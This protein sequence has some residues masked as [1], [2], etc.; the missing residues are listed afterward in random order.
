[1]D[2][3]DIREDLSINFD[4]YYSIQGVVTDFQDGS[5]KIGLKGSDWS[6]KTIVVQ[7][8]TGTMSNHT[9]LLTGAAER[10][11]DSDYQY[12]LILWNTTATSI[13][14]DDFV[15]VDTNYAT[16]SLSGVTISNDLSDAG[17]ESEDSALNSGNDDIEIAGG[18]N[19]TVTR[20]NANKL[21]ISSTDTDT[22]TTYLLK[23]QQTDGNN[24]NPNLFL[25]ASGSDTDD[26]VR[27]VGGS[28][29][30]ITRND[31]GQITFSS[32]DTNTQVT[33]NNNA[34][35]RVI[36]G[37]NTANELNAE[38]N[39][40]F[41]GTKLHLPDNKKITF[42]D[43]TTADLEIFHAGDHSYIVDQGTGELRLRSN[44]FNLQ[45]ADGSKKMI[46]ATEGSNVNLYHNNN[47]KFFT[48]GSTRWNINGSGHIIPDA[49][50]TFDIG[51][52]S[53]RVRNIYTADL[54]CSNKGSSNDVDGTWGDYTIQEGESD[55]FLINNRS[56][57][58]YK[59]N[60]TEVS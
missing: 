51:S 12:W 16:S 32:T 55:L 54:H 48:Q 3:S 56:G 21:T 52:S 37:S 29:M 25:D 36:T 9:F 27:L 17:L 8:G 2:I 22:N 10:G 28:N 24:D 31:D 59:F 13:T 58:K 40:T 45:S 35:N 30:T 43:T 1:M 49:N 4:E 39:L 7:Q 33:V 26:T 19:V 47:I 5:D 20:N 60:L 50:N 57:K 44:L 38:S 46:G 11:G 15:L 23:A 6:G 42:G 41:D 18:T 34:D 14:S 53:Y